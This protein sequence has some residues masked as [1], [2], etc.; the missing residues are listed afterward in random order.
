MSVN[1]AKQG[2][3]ITPGSPLARAL[4]GYAVPGLSAGFADRVMAAA[5]AAPSPLPPLRRPRHSARG[6]RVGQRLAIGIVSFGALA[7]AAA[8]TGLLERFDIAVPSAGTVWA[9]ITGKTPAAAAAPAPVVAD[10][11][12]PAADEAAALAPVEIVGLVDTPEELGEAFRRIDE[13]RE[14]RF[15]A[16]RALTEQRIDSALERRRAA[17]LPL[18]SA[19]QEAAIRGRITAAQERRQQLAEERL[20]LRREELARKVESGEALTREDILRPLRDDAK[21][22][23]R[24]ERIE[25]LQRMSPAQRREALRALPPAERRALIEQYRAGRAAAEP[26]A[27]PTATPSAQPSTTPTAPVS[28]LAGEPSP[29]E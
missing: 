16:R 2:A 25:R 5:E 13:V 4:D 27:A 11:A 1:D 9:S 15:A 29:A 7:T 10:A 22:L 23:E 19:E 14:G 8:A 24:G 28:E 20:R 17:G 21:A 12:K 6:W 26:S 18:P 3:P